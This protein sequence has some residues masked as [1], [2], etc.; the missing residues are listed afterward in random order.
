M[1]SS[2]RYAWYVVGVLMLANISY[3]VDRQIL[4]LLVVPI[5]R[6]LGIT[7]TQMSYLGAI[8]FAVFSTLLALPIARVAD[9]RSRRG[10]IV[11]GSAL[12]SV[13]TAL[14]GLAGT[15]GRLLVARIGVGVGESS[16][17]PAATSLLADLFP[18]DRVSTAMSVF[19]T[20]VFIGSG[21]AYIIGGWIVGLVSTQEQWILPVIGAVH[22]WQ[23]V[24]FAVGLPGLL[25]T[26]L[27]VTVREPDRSQQAR[28]A[29][30]P[31]RALLSYVRSHAR[32]FGCLAF[33]YGFSST[34]NIGIAFWLATFLIEKHGWPPSRAGEVQGALTITIGTLG[35][36][37]GGRMADWFVRRG[38]IDGPL[39]VGIIGASGMLVSATAYP[40]ASSATAA[41][42]WL[43]IVN[44]FAAFPWGAAST[45]AA[46]AVPTSMRAQGT[47]LYFLVVNLLSVGLGPPAV[48]VVADRLFHDKTAVANALAVVNVVGMTAAIILL[49]LGMPAYRR[50]VTTRDA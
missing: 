49:S 11:A 46:E 16:L 36:Y 44:F 13:M 10:V 14:C 21:L 27:L 22:P 43:A 17:Q 37:A 8:P 38:R 6:D 28:A 31:L 24:F 30:V 32:T 45:A 20:A 50:T 9:R 18:V 41:I 39:R 26:L 7:R 33:G 35:V 25:I 23:T 40:L 4:S 47:S 29:R 15:Y 1:K 19:N 12:W 42:V 48:A 3:W 34:V 5:Q 2:E